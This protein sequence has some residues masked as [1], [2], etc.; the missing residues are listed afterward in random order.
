MSEE[1][2]RNGEFYK[3]NRSAKSTNTSYLSLFRE[4]SRHWSKLGNVSALEIFNYGTHYSTICLLVLTSIYR[5]LFDYKFHLIIVKLIMSVLIC[6]FSFGIIEIISAL[7]ETTT[8]SASG[9]SKSPSSLSSSIEVIEGN[10]ESWDIIE[11]SNANNITPTIEVE[12]KFMV[13]DNYKEIL[14]K[15]GFELRQEFDEVLVDT[16]FD[17]HE[18][19]L[20]KVIFKYY[21]RWENQE[22][23]IQ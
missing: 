21:F 17:S 1:I 20:I 11:D 22:F 23:D 12:R 14:L 15:N 8:P 7:T 13:P 2:H 19:H 16:Y 6:L 4:I 5:I 18:H 3:N 9:S 10:D